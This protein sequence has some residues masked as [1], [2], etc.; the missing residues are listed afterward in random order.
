MIQK[1]KYAVASNLLVPRV[2]CVHVF[3]TAW[4]CVCVFSAPEVGLCGRMS[5]YVCVGCR[6]VLGLNVCVSFVCVLVCV[7]VGVC[8]CWCRC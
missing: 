1:M 7:C 5:E 4:T 8:R 2:L 6:F 3:S